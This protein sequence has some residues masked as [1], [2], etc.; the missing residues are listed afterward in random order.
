MT[1]QEGRT[2]LGNA[3]LAAGTL[4][5]VIPVGWLLVWYAFYLRLD[6]YELSQEV[7]GWK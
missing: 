3:F 4:V 5:T 6:V 7:G 1:I 2:H